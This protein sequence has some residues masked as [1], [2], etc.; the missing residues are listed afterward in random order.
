MQNISLLQTQAH[1]QA[2]V[3]LSPEE[4]LA[5]QKACVPVG[6]LTFPAPD[7]IRKLRQHGFVEIVL[8]G[9]QITPAGL[10]R[11]VVERKRGR[12]KQRE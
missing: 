3:L 7:I 4:L 12:A 11:L 10:E 5:L 6:L 2:D 8:G 1:A 9:V